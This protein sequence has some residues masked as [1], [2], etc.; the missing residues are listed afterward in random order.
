M[1]Q[2]PKS[3][4]TACPDAGCSPMDTSKTDK[5]TTGQFPEHGVPPEAAD[6]TS[7]GTPNSDR[8]ETETAVARTDRPDA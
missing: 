1:V 8:G 4:E 2:I 3:V 5:S 7:K 6:A